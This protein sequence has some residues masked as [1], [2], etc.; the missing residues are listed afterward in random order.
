MRTPAAAPRRPCSHLAHTCRPVAVRR[1]CPLNIRPHSPQVKVLIPEPYGGSCSIG[2]ARCGSNVWFATRRRP[3][4]LR[5]WTPRAWL[6][7]P[8]DRPAR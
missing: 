8:L 7:S 1:A 6:T 4:G 2:R 5:G 3:N